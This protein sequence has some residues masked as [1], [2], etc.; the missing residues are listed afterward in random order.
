MDYE[1]KYKEALENMRKFRD[2][3]NNHEE[4][5]LWVLKKD[6][7]TDIEH[8][9]PELVESED[10]KIR[11]WLIALIKSNEY[12][13][14]SNVG[15]MPCSK[16]NVLAWLE[17]QR[18]LAENNE[19]ETD[20][21]FTIYHPLKNGKGIYEC[22]P[23]SFYGTLSSFDEDK[24]MIDFLRLCF[25]TEEE[26]NEWIK[27]N[28]TTDTC[29][30]LIIKSKEFPASEKRDFD[31][32]SETAD[33][34][35]PKFHE[36]EWIIQENI[37]VYKV[38]E[39]CKSWYEVVDNQNNHYSIGFD[40]E[41]MCHLWTPQ[42]AKD[43]DVLCTYECC[44]PKI[45]FI[46]KGAPKKPYV[47]GYHCYYNIMYPHF[48]SDSEKG[49]LA[50][51]DEDVTP[52]T[53]EQC[54]LLFQKMK[55]EG[56]E[57]N[58]EKKEIKKIEEEFNGEDYGIDGLYHAQRILEK[59]LGRVDGYQTDD[60]ILSHQC[61]ISAVKKIYGQKPSKWTEED[62]LHVDSLLKRL[63]GLCNT[64]FA[65]IKDK[66]WLKSLKDRYTLN[67]SDYQLE[68]LENTT[69]NCAYSEYE[70]CLRELIV[71]LKKLKA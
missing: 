61:A 27:Q 57:W 56:Y 48:G 12:G 36:G 32:F 20:I 11:K 54:D 35:K 28:E 44:E 29:K 63:D 37:G 16:L 4:T 15:K 65:T 39:V 17:K 47:L 49:C 50:P 62:E 23:Y 40:K 19:D 55:E 5:D 21:D 58:A 46:L 9:F 52:A 6:V 59:T 1:K 66:E 60:G 24:D 10:E 70:D 31:Y 64:R 7:V 45:V 43:G 53:K 22:I 68:A 42:D 30:S 51:N 38:I 69:E 14:I 2:A 67:V 34:V 33:K 8:Y 13:S 3:L 25:Y 41:Y 71:E 18:K 26:C